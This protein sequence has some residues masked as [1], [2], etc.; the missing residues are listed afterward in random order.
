M[1]RRQQHHKIPDIKMMRQF[2]RLLGL[3]GVS[4]MH[5]VHHHPA[6]FSQSGVAF[7]QHVYGMGLKEAKDWVE[8]K[9][10][11]YSQEQETELDRIRGA[12]IIHETKRT[13][14]FM[15]FLQRLGVSSADTGLAVCKNF[16]TRMRY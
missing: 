5:R 11:Y 9:Y 2:T 4:S 7:D 12:N 16:V 6:A 14:Q 1:K 13:R 8:S 3:C 15:S 10:D